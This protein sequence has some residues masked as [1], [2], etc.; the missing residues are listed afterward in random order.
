M[1][2]GVKSAKRII[3][4]N[5]DINGSLNT[6]N[7]YQ[8]LLAQRNCPD[9]ESNV[10]PAQV[11]CGHAVR[12]II[13]ATDYAPRE[14]WSQLAT[15]QEECFLRRHFR[16]CEPLESQARNLTELLPGDLVCIQDQAGPTPK[17]W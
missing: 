9:P 17:K 3:R 10:S 13:P 1:E 12:D 7:F 2:L 5:V 6:N 16:K 4:D 14:E 11:V 8:A 15:R